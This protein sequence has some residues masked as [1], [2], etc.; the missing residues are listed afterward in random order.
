MFFCLNTYIVRK[1]CTYI[2]NFGYN[3]MATGKSSGKPVLYRDQGCVLGEQV[4]M[5]LIL[6][7]LYTIYPQLLQ[8]H[9]N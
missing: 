5:G 2:E 7:G 3:I 1:S 8:T 4:A 9:C 6:K